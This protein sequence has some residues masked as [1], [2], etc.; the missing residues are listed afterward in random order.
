MGLAAGHY[1]VEMPASSA[2]NEA[3]NSRGWYQEIDLTGDAELNP[4]DAPAFATV[5]GFVSFPGEAS[6][7]KGASVRISDPMTGASFASAISDKGQVDFSADAVRAGRY[8]LS[9]GSSQG[10][11]LGKLS[12]T[13]AR[14]TGRTLEIGGGSS[15]H[16]VGV[17]TRG[18]GQVDGVALRD[19]Q[20]F[21]GAMIV[22]VPYDPAHNSP[23]F[24]RDQ[25]DSDGTFT[26]PN[27]VPGKY[28][29]VAIANG[30]DLEWGSPVALGPYLERGEA[31]QVAAGGKLQIKVQVQ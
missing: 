28:T 9:L 4:G 25:S 16:F 23:L 13:G 30:W 5:S 14:L 31:V 2:G 17:A 20:P 18:V 6:V 27:V 22:L 8:N 24:R 10:F 26:L 12:A 15:V 7:P 11:F 1:V 21:A 29:V 3:S 19:G